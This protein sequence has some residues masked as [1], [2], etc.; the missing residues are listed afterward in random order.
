MPAAQVSRLTAFS[1]VVSESPLVLTDV[2][3]DDGTVGHSMVFTYTAAALKPTADLIQN[4]EA[5]V[6]GEPMAPIEL[7]QKL[8]RKFR[9]LG[10]QG[11]VGIALAAIDMALWDA[12]RGPTNTSLIRLLGGLETVPGLWGGRIRRAGDCQ[13]GGRMGRTRLQGREGQDRLCDGSRGR[14]GHPGHSQSG[15][16]RH[17]DHGRL[18]PVP[19]PG[20]GRRRLHILDDEG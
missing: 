12:L 9:L 2:L 10:T 15:R 18:Q 5:L 13:S 16:R 8:L 20:R 11:L 7:E 17:R 6:V 4:I 3:A 14:G 19:H 1:G